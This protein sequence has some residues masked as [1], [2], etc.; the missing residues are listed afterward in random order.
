MGNKKICQYEIYIQPLSGSLKTLPIIIL[1]YLTIPLSLGNPKE[2]SNAKRNYETSTHSSSPSTKKRARTGE[3]GQSTWSESD[4][5]SSSSSSSSQLE[6]FE[7]KNAFKPRPPSL[8]LAPTGQYIPVY[9]DYIPSSL[10]SILAPPKSQ[11]FYGAS[12]GNSA[13][14]LQAIGAGASF[15][16]CFESGHTP[17]SLAVMNSLRPV[18]EVLLGFETD[19]SKIAKLPK[20]KLTDAV[21][22][23]QIEAVTNLFNQH[24]K[25]TKENVLEAA[26]IAVLQ[27]NF[28]MLESIRTLAN[29]NLHHFDLDDYF[30]NKTKLISEN[31]HAEF[32]ALPEKALADFL[33]S[34][35]TFAGLRNDRTKLRIAHLKNNGGTNN[36]GIFGVY[37]E[38]NP[39]P[40][41]FIKVT[42]VGDDV[43]HSNS[44]EGDRWVQLN[45]SVLHHPEFLLTPEE[46]ESGSPAL[47]RQDL[48]YLPKFIKTV[49]SGHDNTHVYSVIEAARGEDLAEVLEKLRSGEQPET[50]VQDTFYSIGRQVGSMVYFFSKSDRKNPNEI[51]TWKNRDEGLANYFYDSSTKTFTVIDNSMI[52][53]RQLLT[54]KSLVKF[55]IIK[56]IMD[57]LFI[58]ETDGSIDPKYLKAYIALARGLLAPLG[59]PLLSATRHGLSE[60][61]TGT[62]KL[63]IKFESKK[64]AKKAHVS[65]PELATIVREQFPELDACLDGKF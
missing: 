1:T 54:N 2:V 38:G 33:L 48:R 31:F 55:S 65:S 20:G 21:R 46:R 56:S 30:V 45:S 59:E 15:D 29:T 47:H 14:V 25:P 17:L 49:E 22:N 13:L 62:L 24:L 19:Q 50:W 8:H 12:T 16:E 36:D 44:H 39:K 52:M 58:T 37:Q 6:T 23:N 5:S 40:T 4:S 41:Y 53:G 9:Q 28:E 7:P 42:G 60:I 51:Y 43:S 35:P 32:N 3:N 57:E 64:R 18:I 11:L 34:T 27:G 61:C 10:W 63:A 26:N